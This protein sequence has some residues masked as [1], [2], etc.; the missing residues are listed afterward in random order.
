[1]DEATAT[2]PVLTNQVGVSERAGK[3]LT[4]NLAVESYGLEILKV[5]EIIGMM[6]ITSV[7]KTPAHVKGVINLRGRVIPVVDLRLKFGL[8]EAEHTEETCIIVVDVRGTQTGIIVDT[9]DEVLDIGERDIE[10]APNFG[11]TVNTRFILGVA[12]ID[13]DVKILLDIDS[14]LTSEDLAALKVAAG[15]RG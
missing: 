9:V 1:M 12:K 5:R 8:E 10:D 2:T 3:Y 13:G 11:D 14:V 6:D 15:S 7:P 4:F